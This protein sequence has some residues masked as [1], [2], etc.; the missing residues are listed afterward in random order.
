[1]KIFSWVN[2]PYAVTRFDQQVYPETIVSSELI[3]TPFSSLQFHGYYPICLIK[4]CNFIYKSHVWGKLRC[5]DVGA[6][7]QFVWK[8]QVIQEVLLILFLY[9]KSQEFLFPVFPG[10]HPCMISSLKV[11]CKCYNEDLKVLSALSYQ[12]SFYIF[13]KTL[14]LKRSVCNVMF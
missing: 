12:H 10:Q 11:T 5:C 6:C 4:T 9:C 14:Q 8:Q 13:K 2:F 3:L 7:N 1:M